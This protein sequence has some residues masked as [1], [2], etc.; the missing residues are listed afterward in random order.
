LLRK[1][2]SPKN[3]ATAHRE[4]RRSRVAGRSAEGAADPGCDRGPGCDCDGDC[5]TDPDTDTD[6]N[7]SEPTAFSLTAFYSTSTHTLP[8]WLLNSGAYM[9]PISAMPL[10]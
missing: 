8:E 9:H 4:G 10:W 1:A 3:C 5:D 7:P 6:G 2:I